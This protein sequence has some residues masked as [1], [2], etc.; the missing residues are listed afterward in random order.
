MIINP[1]ASTSRGLDLWVICFLTSLQQQLSLA[2]LEKLIP[3]GVRNAL[4]E[5]CFSSLGGVFAAIYL[6]IHPSASANAIEVV[7][8]NISVNL[9]ETTEVKMG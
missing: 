6:S 4:G 5:M 9:R 3:K 7:S 8:R 2:L 1:V